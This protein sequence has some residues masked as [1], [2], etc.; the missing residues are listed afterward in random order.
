MSE[1]HPRRVRIVSPRTR[2]ARSATGRPVSREIGEQT[3]VGEVYMRSLV[4]VQLRLAIGILLIFTVL[5]GGLPLLLLAEP[6]LADVH[7]VGLPSPLAAA[8]RGRAPGARP[9]RPALR[10]A[11]RAQRAGL[12]RGRPMN[13][14]R[15]SDEQPVR[16]HRDRTGH[17]RDR[18]D[19]RLRAAAVPDHQRLL[20]RVALGEPVVER[21]GDRRRVPLGRV[22]PRHRRPDPGLRRGH[23]VVPGRLH[24]GLP[25]AAGA[26]RRAAAPVR[27]LHAARLRRGPARVAAGAPDRQRPRRDD[28]LALPAAAVRRRRAHRAPGDRGAGLGRR[29]AGRRRR[30]VQRRDGR[31]AQHHL[32]AGVPVLAQAHRAGRAGALPRHR[33]AG[34]RRAD[35]RGRPAG[36]P[37]AHRR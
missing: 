28:R 4:R 20:R 14:R 18:A 37:G 11:G 30:R 3:I 26:G 10:A 16:R 25:R 2:A 9:R 13:H 21:V 17:R 35:D 6:Q 15:A 27:R 19:R 34:G 12:L 24:R 7:V 29:P 5:L 23:A 1:Q 33:L 22:L 8:R 32:R 31:H 36:L